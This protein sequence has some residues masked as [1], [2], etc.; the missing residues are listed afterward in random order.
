M[1]KY[2]VKCPTGSRIL[3]FSRKDAEKVAARIEG[4][5]ILSIPVQR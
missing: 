4:A 3:A 1:S 5:T 2:Y